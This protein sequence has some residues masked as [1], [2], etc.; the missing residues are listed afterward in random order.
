VTRAKLAEK[1][2]EFGGNV[3]QRFAPNNLR[4]AG[5]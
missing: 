3:R 4:A 1:A 5:D 2:Q